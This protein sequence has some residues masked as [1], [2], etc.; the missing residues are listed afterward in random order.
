MRLLGATPWQSVAGAFCVAFMNGESRWGAGNAGTFQVGLYTQTWALAAFPIALGHGARWISQGK[1]LPAAIAWGA[2]VGLCHP[3]AVLVLGFGLV[4]S[5]V[6][7][8]IPRLET[9]VWPSVA[10]RTLAMAGI[11]IAMVLPRSW[12][13]F[14]P[15]AIPALFGCLLIAAGIALPI[16]YRTDKTKWIVEKG[17]EFG[18]E[19]ARTAIL[20]GLMVLAWM[21]V[22]LPLLADY[23]GFG[24]FPH[25]VSD[26]V[27]PG[28][29]GLGH[30]F[31]H[32][33]H[34]DILDWMP[35]KSGTRLPILT[36]ALPL[37]VIF[38]RSSLLRW[39]WPP[40]LLYGL[41]L[42]LG[43]HLGKI[44]DDLF[45]P[46][47]ALGAMQIVLALGIGAGAII[48][49]KLLWEGPW[50]RWLARIGFSPAPAKK[51]EQSSTV[52]GVRTLIAAAAA[53]LVVLIAVP[54]GRSLAW[55]VHV[56][57]DYGGSHRDE[58]LQINEIVAKQP[59]GRK[60]VGPGAENHW[61]NLL[62]YAYDG[63]P[64]LLQMGGGG[65]QASPNYDYLWSSRDHVKNAWVYDAPYLVFQ[66][67]K[68]DKM[69]VG[70]TIGSTENYEVR[71]L[72][73]PGLVSPVQITGVLPPGY[74]AGQPGHKAALDWIKGELPIKDQVFAYKGFGD[75]TDP[76]DA[77]TLR[78][79]RQDS[80]GDEADIVA[81][82][83]ANKPSTFVIRES[84]HPRWH[85]YVDGNETAVHRVTPDFPAVDVPAG[86]HTI[87]LRFE[88]P[89]WT[90]AVY[91]V[92]PG[93]ALGAW[94]FM[95]RRKK[96]N[97]PTATALPS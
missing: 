64:S 30:W 92:W 43:P 1:G 57:G 49:G 40:A 21:P 42:G 73:S 8:L 28:F 75:R 2:F 77:K 13:D 59:P 79:W 83:E 52:Y 58:L 50:E 26:E 82:V 35:D 25:R 14:M 11:V 17:D 16:V 44:G 22:W 32:G 86:K 46:V 47:R 69:P 94:L 55:R 48:I 61:W 45:P 68:G 33:G 36:Y 41:L 71:K 10:G 5:V 12:F 95:R 7:R 67:S 85:A 62:G 70:E 89:W 18:W 34:A 6:A 24:G 56:L 74:H 96:T 81:E 90:L 9:L 84:W 39:L 19:M 53:G 60:Q 3:F 54:G 29:A 72:P 37:V 80:P 88:R 15:D 97:L 38:A 63:I 4:A 91:L 93:T 78:S 51:G 20:G 65:L 23:S 76:P 87:E 31:A 27:G 66:K